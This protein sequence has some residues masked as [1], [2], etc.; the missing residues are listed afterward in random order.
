MVGSESQRSGA[1]RP[2]GPT[3]H[4][5]PVTE[6]TAREY[7]FNT[8]V[9]GQAITL[10]CMPGAARRSPRLNPGATSD[11]KPGLSPNGSLSWL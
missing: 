6:N 3:T 4:A 10:A 7:K 8:E 1:S 5:T 2:V 9:H 11:R